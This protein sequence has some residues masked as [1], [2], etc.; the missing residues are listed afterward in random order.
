M[1]ETLDPLPVE[2]KTDPIVTTKTK[3]V[4]ILLLV[5]IVVSVLM[6]VLAWTLPGMTPP[7]SGVLM[8]FAIIVL[9]LGVSA[10]YTLNTS[11]ISVSVPASH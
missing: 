11:F 4:W 8:I 9:L 3:L 2:S 6:V 1:A 5:I 7:N 10:I